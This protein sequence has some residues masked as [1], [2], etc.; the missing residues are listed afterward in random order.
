MGDKLKQV[1]MSLR[2]AHADVQFKAMLNSG[3]RYAYAGALTG[4]VARLKA[5]NDCNAVLL[6][7]TFFPVGVGIALPKGVVHKKYFDKV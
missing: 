5:F 1:P 4:T 7:E 3:D 6:P 2:E